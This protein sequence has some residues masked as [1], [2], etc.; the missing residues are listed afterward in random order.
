[1]CNCRPSPQRENGI[2][3]KENEKSGFSFFF[4]LLAMPVASTSSRPRDGTQA[5]AGLSAGLESLTAGQLSSLPLQALLHL[6]GAC[7]SL[8]F[9]ATLLLIAY[10]SKSRSKSQLGVRVPCLP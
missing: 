9:L 3:L 2:F 7:Y 6:S 8:Y 1:M 10:K 4:F 5:S